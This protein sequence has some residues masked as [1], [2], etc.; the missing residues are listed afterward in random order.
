MSDRFVFHGRLGIGDVITPP[1]DGWILTLIDGTVPSA[2]LGDA[3]G[4]GQVVRVLGRPTMAGLDAW[5]NALT[6]SGRIV[7]IGDGAL[8]DAA[9]LLFGR[10][11]SSSSDG[12]AL[13]LVPAGR[14]AYRAVTPYAVVDADGQRPTSVDPLYA[15]ADILVSPRLLGSAEIA[16]VAGLAGDAAVQSMEVLLSRRCDE[17]SRLLAMSVL[18]AIAA[19]LDAALS[20]DPSIRDAARTRLV[21]ATFLGAEATW[22]TRLGIAHAIASPLGTLTGLTHDVFHVVIGAVA[23]AEWIA[24]PAMTD[25]ATALGVGD[26]SGVLAWLARTRDRCGLPAGLQDL[27]VSWEDVTSVLPLAMQS[28]GVAWLPRTIDLPVLERI[29]SQAW[30]GPSDTG[31]GIGR[32]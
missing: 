18:R 14:E 32:T 2:G 5:S 11:T 13:T 3:S 26:G 29:A 20:D 24:E 12:W 16:I 10:L 15:S 19:E 25:I 1:G 6:G 23:V 8:L 9:K 21:M 17:M 22:V 7:A 4:A 27:G 28:S 30:A 31:G